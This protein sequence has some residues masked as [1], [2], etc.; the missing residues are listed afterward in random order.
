MVIIGGILIFIF[1]NVVL[2][3]FLSKLFKHKNSKVK[4]KKEHNHS[5]NSS[6]AKL[7]FWESIKYLFLGQKY[8]YII[9]AITNILIFIIYSY[10][11]TLFALNVKE[12]SLADNLKNSYS[13]TLLSDKFS[14]PSGY[15]YF[16]CGGYVLLFLA[17][18]PFIEIYI[19]RKIIVSWKK[20]NKLTLLLYVPIMQ[21][22]V[23]IALLVLGYTPEIVFAN[24]SRK[25]KNEIKKSIVFLNNPKELSKGGVVSSSENIANKIKSSSLENFT[26]VESNP[27]KGAVLSYLKIPKIGKDTLYKTIIIPYQLDTPESKK[28]KL[29]FNILLFPDNT[30]VVNKIDKKMIEKLVP[31]LTNKMVKLELKSLTTS[32]SPNISFLNEIDYV[33]YQ[34]KQEEKIK[35][36]FESYIADLNNYIKESDTIIQT[37]QGVID[38]YPSAK[39]KAQREYEEYVAKWSGW[40]QECKSNFGEDPYCAEGKIAFD[41]GIKNLEAGIRFVNKIGNTAEKNLNIQIVYKNEA[42]KDLE[43]IKQ[44]YQNFLKNPITAVLQAGVFNPPN[45][46]FI[47]YYD[48]EHKPLTYYLNA[49][50]HEDLHFLSFSPDYQLDT[51]LDEGFTDYLKLIILAKYVEPEAL[52]LSYPHEVAIVDGLTKYFPQEKLIQ[53]YLDQNQ[54]SFQFLFVNAYSPLEYENFVRKGKSLS[55]LSLKDETLRNKYVGEIQDILKGRNK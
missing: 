16:V 29:S 47:R 55:Y 36:E 45:D 2:F 12:F 21:V 35:K 19:I 9:F 8:F 38:S 41:N 32:K 20:I 31:I 3:L 14:C 10:N 46:I 6:K 48:K 27:L 53:S 51:F 37:N 39:Q 1:I 23:F 28:I 7:S 25:A 18:L 11:L 42:L 15:K 49:V 43:I 30:L 52:L 50:L 54:T 5:I 17:L 26:I 13:A 40:Y 4:N 22:F 34:T 44:N 33:V 24:L